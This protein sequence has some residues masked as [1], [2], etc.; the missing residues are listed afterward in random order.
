MPD[1]IPRV[2]I[3]DP[4]V[5]EFGTDHPAGYP[6]PGVTLWRPRVAVEA[7]QLTADADWDAIAEWCGGTHHLGTMYVDGAEAREGDWIVRHIRM[8]GCPEFRVYAAKPFAATYDPAAS[9][10]AADDLLRDVLVAVCERDGLSLESDAEPGEPARN[11]ELAVRLRIGRVFGLADPA[12]PGP[13]LPP[14]D[15]PDCCGER[16]AA[17]PQPAPPLPPGRWGRI[18]IPGF[19]NDTGWIDVAPDGV[20]KLVRDWDGALI[21]EV[22]PGPNSRVVYLPTPQK[23][24]EPQQAITRGAGMRPCGCDGFTVCDECGSPDEPF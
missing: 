6:P 15:R 24:P 13:P 12:A 17:E 11:Y 8:S 18:E 20:T 16:E 14:C 19:R 7:V 23:R 5:S 1:E 10:A 3:Q 21:A 9:A 2:V 22:T 4:H